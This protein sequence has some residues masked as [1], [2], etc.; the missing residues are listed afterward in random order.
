MSGQLGSMDQIIASSN[1]PFTLITNPNIFFL[2]KKQLLMF[3]SIASI[4]AFSIDKADVPSDVP[5]GIE[6]RTQGN[7][8]PLRLWYAEKQ[9]NEPNRGGLVQTEK[10]GWYFL[11]HHGTGAWEGRC[12]SLVPVTWIDAWP[13]I[14]QPDDKGIGHFVWLGKKPVDNT[15]IVTP[16]TSDE[17]NETNLPP[18]WEWN[19]QP[20]DDKWS[21]TE[22]P[23]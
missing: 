13:I 18:Q 8:D 21:L 6:G 4:T 5:A 19:C 22:R 11:T 1:W 23:G 14:G 7:G 9:F 17:F 16:Q 12:D 2:Q 15:P 20:R 3:M 10:G